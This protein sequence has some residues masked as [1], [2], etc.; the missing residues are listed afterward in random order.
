[1]E[2]AVAEAVARTTRE[3][4]H[5]D[6][7]ADLREL[8]RQAVEAG[9]D[10]SR[11]IIK[12][13]RID[14]RTGEIRYNPAGRLLRDWYFHVYINDL[15][16][17]LGELSEPIDAQQIEDCA[18]LLHRIRPEAPPLTALQAV[19]VVRNTARDDAAHAAAEIASRLRS[20]VVRRA[21]LHA[22]DE[23]FDANAVRVHVSRHWYKRCYDDCVEGATQS[24]M[25]LRAVTDA[26][27]RQVALILATGTV[28]RLIGDDNVPLVT[29]HSTLVNEVDRRLAEG[30]IDVL[31]AHSI[32]SLS[33]DATQP[34]SAQIQGAW[35][36]ASEAERV[37][38]ARLAD[39]EGTEP[40]G[41]WHTLGVQ[42]QTRLIRYYLEAHR[43]DLRDRA[44]ES[45]VIAAEPQIAA[46]QM[47]QHPSPLPSYLAQSDE[48]ARRVGTLM[49]LRDS[50]SPEILPTRGLGRGIG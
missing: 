40:P 16:D 25:P 4:A 36:Y 30:E 35:A 33:F 6:A 24:R 32:A 22:G 41:A 21:V 1:M 39:A 23:R 34:L 11:K 29:A 9:R 38:W 37:R 14:P 48:L 26:E 43:G 13:S 18:A 45:D 47:F 44:F 46:A 28:R 3:Q 42:A 2:P 7:T 5:H 27:E 31:P 50:T 17:R 49:T 19:G 10:R 12:V 15:R 20:V 8:R